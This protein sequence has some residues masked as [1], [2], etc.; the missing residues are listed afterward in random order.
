M[1]IITNTIITNSII[2]QYHDHQYLHCH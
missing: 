2:I 1:N